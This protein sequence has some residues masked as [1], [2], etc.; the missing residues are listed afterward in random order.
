MYF[1]IPSELVGSGSSNP[2][3]I[4]KFPYAPY[5]PWP[6]KDALNSGPLPK[7]P[8]AENWLLLL[9]SLWCPPVTLIEGPWVLNDVWWLV[10]YLDPGP[11]KLTEGPWVLKEVC[12]VVNCPYLEYYLDS[13]PERLIFGP[14]VLKEVCWVELENCPSLEY[15][16]GPESETEGPCPENCPGPETLTLVLCCPSPEYCVEGPWRLRDGA[17]PE[18]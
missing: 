12:W 16:L 15:V 1:F 5:C 3:C 8:W 13:G 9:N 2:P 7:F 10:Y 11:D 14:W 17:C 18:Y 4:L 6:P